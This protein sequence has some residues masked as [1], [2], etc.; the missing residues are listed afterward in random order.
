MCGA[1]AADSHLLD[2]K[3]WAR[4]L[5]CLHGSWTKSEVAMFSSW[6]EDVSLN[7]DRSLIRRHRDS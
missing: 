6:I 1:G 2:G 3:A 7:A 5:E 4:A